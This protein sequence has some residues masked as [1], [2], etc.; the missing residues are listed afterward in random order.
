MLQNL[1]RATNKWEAANAMQPEEAPSTANL[2][3]RPSLHPKSSAPTAKAS[4]TKEQNDRNQRKLLAQAM[5]QRVEAQANAYRLSSE[6]GPES[7]APTPSNALPLP[8][9]E[10]PTTATA[11]DLPRPPVKTQRQSS[12]PQP[13]KRFRYEPSAMGQGPA[14]A[15]GF[16]VSTV[17]SSPAQLCVVDT[18][19]SHVLFREQD[20]GLLSHV[21]MSPP[22]SRPFA[23]LKAANG[24][25]LN[26]IGRGMLTIKTVTVVEY[27][28]RNKDLV[29][30]LLGI[31]PFADRGC[32]ATFT[33]SQFTLHHLGKLP[34]L[35][36]RRHAHNLWR[37]ELP[38]TVIPSRCLPSYEPHQVLLLH[39]TDQ[40]PDAEYV[41][42]VHAALGSPPPT[43]FLRAVARG[44]ING[45]R[46]FSRLTTK[47]VRRNMPNSEASAR[48]HLR[49]TPTAQ[50][51]AQSEAVSALRRHHNAKAIQDLWRQMK[52]K[53]K[54]SPFSTF[55][56][57][58]YQGP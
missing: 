35:V 14:E 13:N 20:S 40:Q 10:N 30:N 41:R 1:C 23:I 42:F 38:K 52:T 16:T 44:F 58:G 48:G 57:T 37:I 50:P 19:A 5:R 2:S 53:A 56:P 15:S 25:F 36:G 28:F 7:R 21:E 45:P 47:M 9:I 29:V 54:S 24:A 51:H 49:K 43:T 3:K 55:D 6:I 32:T 11:T 33:A 18:G 27:I 46:Q 31:A 12:R 4:I 26:A 39:Q 8:V 17:G 22:D 34:I